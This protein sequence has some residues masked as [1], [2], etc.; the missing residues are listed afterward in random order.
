MRACG[1]V[2]GVVFKGWGSRFIGQLEF[3]W[4]RMGFLGLRC[5]WLLGRCS[6]TCTTFFSLLR[7]A[8]LL[9]ELD[10]FLYKLLFFLASRVEYDSAWL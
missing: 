1:T 2:L 4:D 7:W 3:V 10:C 8:L 9:L 6:C 5:F